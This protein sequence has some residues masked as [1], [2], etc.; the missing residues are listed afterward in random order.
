MECQ[1]ML[2]VT[3][4]NDSEPNALIVALTSF[5]FA[6]IGFFVGMLLILPLLAKLATLITIP[7]PV[8]ATMVF[9]G[10][11]GTPVVGALLGINVFSRPS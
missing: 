11:F 10:L 3:S 4:A 1:A 7:D 6:C 2:H 9:I 8:M 5:G